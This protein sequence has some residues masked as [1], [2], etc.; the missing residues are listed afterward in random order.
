[1]NRISAASACCI[2]ACVPACWTKE[3]RDRRVDHSA[4]SGRHLLPFRRVKPGAY[5]LKEYFEW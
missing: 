1:M 3:E 4:F 5:A 2:G